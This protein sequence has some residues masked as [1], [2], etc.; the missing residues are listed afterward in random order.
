[1]LDGEVPVFQIRPQLPWP[2]ETIADGIGECRVAGELTSVP[3]FQATELPC[4]MLLSDPPSVLRRLAPY[5][6]LDLIKL[7][8]PLEGL[9]GNAGAARQADIKKRHGACAGPATSLIL[10][11][12]KLLESGIA[13]ACSQP[14]NP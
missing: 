12:R 9:L 11:V 5:R 13:L 1:M 3:S 2:L 7:G 8:D 10:P 14:S 6:L 4:G